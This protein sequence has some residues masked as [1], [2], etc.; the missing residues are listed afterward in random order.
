M[1]VTVDVLDAD[2]STMY[3]ETFY[4][5]PDALPARPLHIAR[6]IEK[7]MV[8]YPA[9]QTITVELEKDDDDA[10]TKTDVQEPPRGERS[11]E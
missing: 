10:T 2:A 8:A 5:L 9:Y 7:L 6:E 11:P 4:D 3:T 1:K